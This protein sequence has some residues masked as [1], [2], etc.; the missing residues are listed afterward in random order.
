MGVVFE[1]ILVLYFF[2]YFKVFKI[3][4]KDCIFLKWIVIWERYVYYIVVNFYVS[5]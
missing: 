5:N 1:D 4:K 3:N 2:L